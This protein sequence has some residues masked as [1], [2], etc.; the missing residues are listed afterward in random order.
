MSKTGSPKAK[1]T[2]A[3]ARAAKAE[4]FLDFDES[5]EEDDTPPMPVKLFGEIWYVPGELPAAVPLKLA[6]FMSDGRADDTLADFELI[7]L[8]GDV[9]PAPVMK[10]WQ[11][12]GITTPKLGYVLMGI[13]KAYG[14]DITAVEGDEATGKA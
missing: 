4:R 12:K 3:A 7:D 2:A 6:R 13:L 1:A 11:D 10:A 5:M 8:A 14:M 9:V